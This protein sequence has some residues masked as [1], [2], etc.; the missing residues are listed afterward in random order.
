MATGIAF[1]IR[2]MGAIQP[3][4]LKS[5][6]PSGQ[7][8]ERI[9]M[10]GRGA[11]DALNQASQLRYRDRR[12]GTGPLETLHPFKIY[13]TP[14]E[15]ADGVDSSTYW[16]T[17]RVRAGRVLGWDAT[18]T[19]AATDDVPNSDPDALYYPSGDVDIVVPETTAKFWF[20]IE[21]NAG[22]AVV[23]YGTDPTATQ[24]PATG[25]ALWTSTNSWGAAPIP[26]IS[27]VPIGWID[28]NTHADELRAVVR[29]LL[30][31][32][33]VFTGGGDTLMTLVSYHQSAM[34][35]DYLICRPD[36]GATD[37]SA[38]VNVEVE[39]Q[40]QSSI[41]TQ[42]MPDGVNWTYAYTLYDPSLQKRQATGGSVILTENISPPFIAGNIIPVR[43]C[44]NSKATVGGVK[45][46]LIAITGRQWAQ[47]ADYEVV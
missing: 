19:D 9:N 45:L 29:Q 14:L 36:G 11:A 44:S 15:F 46:S 39:P 42:T 38:D 12:P 32:D 40:L 41:A 17:F 47:W 27:H 18:G 6:E 7:N 10:A 3:R 26:D 33:V 37:G 24:Y 25:T 1:S 34:N 21:I 23:R 4:P 20:W 13:Q 2:D 22:A 31:A 35:G 16:R 43:A 28:T 5:G 30:R 8:W